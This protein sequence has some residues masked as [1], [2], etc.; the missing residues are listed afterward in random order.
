MGFAGY[1]KANAPDAIGSPGSPGEPSACFPL[2]RLASSI[3]TRTALRICDGCYVTSSQTSELANLDLVLSMV[4]IY[5]CS[6]TA[7]RM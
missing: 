7:I 2:A 5:A 4:G 3:E 1:E 6:V